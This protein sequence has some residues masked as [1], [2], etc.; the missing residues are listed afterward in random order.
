[1]Q[2]GKTEEATADLG[3]PAGPGRVRFTNLSASQGTL[4]DHFLDILTVRGPQRDGGRGDFDIRS[5]VQREA[6]GGR[7]NCLGQGLA[8]EPW[9]S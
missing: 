3:R 8:W 7:A 1:M 2:I 6:V 9:R 5:R 4:V